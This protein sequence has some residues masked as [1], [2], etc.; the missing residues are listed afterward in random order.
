MPQVLV[1]LILCKIKARV[2]TVR[3]GRRNPSLAK[4]FELSH[5][6][7]KKI[8][9]LGA[10][11]AHLN[12]INKRAAMDVSNTNRVS[13]VTNFLKPNPWRFNQR[14]TIIVIIN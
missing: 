3:D 6:L 14:D 12:S 8:N 5:Y 10:E 11:V 1:F 4:I 9:L 2:T 7:L 13:L